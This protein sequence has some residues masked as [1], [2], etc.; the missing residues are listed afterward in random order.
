MSWNIKQVKENGSKNHVV[1][2]TTSEVNTDSVESFKQSLFKAYK[3]KDIETTSDK[4]MI[5]LMN[6]I[7]TQQRYVFCFTRDSMQDLLKQDKNWGKTKG[8]KDDTWRHIKY[9]LYSR[10][11]IKE[12]HPGSSSFPGIYEVI[13]PMCLE[14]LNSIFGSE[15]QKT[16]DQNEQQAL[17]FIGKKTLGN[18]TLGTETKTKAKKKT[19]NTDVDQET[20]IK[21]T[22]SV[23]NRVGSS[24]KDE[25]VCDK[26]TPT[27]SW[28][29][30]VDAKKADVC[31]P[32]AECIP[33]WN[34]DR[35]NLKP[36][37]EQRYKLMCNLINTLFYYGN[38][39]DQVLKE[40]CDI[41]E[42]FVCPTLEDEQFCKIM[43]LV[44]KDF[45]RAMTNGINAFFNTPWKK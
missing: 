4:V 18:D 17:D 22:A 26:D 37:P 12:I 23:F 34:Q 15:S 16:R 30:K 28:K 45:D 35:E 5:T 42:L 41:V 38:N 19:Q 27:S 29:Y 43:V 24:F 10:N 2:R 7:L 40:K 21:E 32:V 36:S 44:S 3:D 33:L 20:V 25:S 31:V 6:A 13:D 1:L 11:I 14:F 39:P 8:F 9:D